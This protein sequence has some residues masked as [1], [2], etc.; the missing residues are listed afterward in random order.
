[1]HAVMTGFIERGCQ[2]GFFHFDAAA[3]GDFPPRLATIERFSVQLEGPLALER[4]R[5]WRPDLCFSHNMA[6]LDVEAELVRS[7]PVVKF[8]HAFSG[9]CISQLKMHRWPWPTPCERA[10]GPPCLALYLPRRCGPISF[11]A[12]TAGYQ[13]A[14]RQQEL[15]PRY[16]AMVV[17]S[18]AMR[19]EFIRNSMPADRIFVEPLFPAERAEDSSAHSLPEIPT[20]LFAGRMTFLKGGDFLVRAAANVQKRLGRPIRLIMAGDGPQRSS[21]QSLAGRQGV[22]ASF[23]GWLDADRRDDVARNA[24]LVAVPS[25]W[26]EPYGLVGPECGR[27]GLPAIA[28]DVGGVREWLKDG[29]TG[30]LVASRPPTAPALADGLLAALSDPAELIRRGDN[31]RRASRESSLA[32]HLDGLERIFRTIVA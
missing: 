13:H 15:F 26:P 4:A 1:M 12:M 22:D 14:Q 8:M 18:A 16:R 27:L 24:S 25:V 3:P 11:S 20:V 28:F 32:R 23:P 30:W 10:F 5:N 21:W 6:P 19:A 17:A 9:T 31:A 2:V 29:A 7:F